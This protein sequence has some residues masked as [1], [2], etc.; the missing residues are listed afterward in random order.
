MPAKRKSAKPNVAPELS[1]RQEAREWP[2]WI[3]RLRL[4]VQSE[5]PKKR[6]WAEKAGS[7]LMELMDLSEESLAQ[8][9]TAPDNWSAMLR[10]MAAPENLRQLQAADPLAPAFLRGIE[11]QRRL[12]KENG[13]VY[14]TDRVAEFL[15]ITPQAVN[16]RRN[17]RKLL[18]VTFRKRGYV[19]P[20]WQFDERGTVPG[21]EDVLQSLAD[22]D[23]WMQNVFFITPNPRLNSLRPLDLLKRGQLAEVL[24]AAKSFG[25]H[26][27]A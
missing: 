26:G 12:M 1:T 14:N 2:E 25:V 10:A 11:A 27:A 4:R 23:E 20:I 21:L 22:H 13:G 17:S 5:S 24:Q 15:G 9:A 8:A 7:L 19:Y 3:E 6:D 18:G 16:K